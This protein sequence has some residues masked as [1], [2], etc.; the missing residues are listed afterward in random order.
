MLHNRIFPLA[1]NYRGLYHEAATGGVDR[2]T[3]I[4]D[5]LPTAYS[6]KVVLRLDQD[7]GFCAL[8]LSA[9][10][11]LHKKDGKQAASDLLVL[12]SPPLSDTELLLSSVLYPCK[13]WVM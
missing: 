7:I 10:K 9:K 3:E 5:C 2:L 11:I 6:I 8:F 1:N 13:L 12:T 4:S